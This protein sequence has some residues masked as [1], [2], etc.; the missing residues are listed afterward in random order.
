MFTGVW[1]IAGVGI[2]KVL[3]IGFPY[4]SSR[5]RFVQLVTVSLSFIG[6]AKG[7]SAIAKRKH[8]K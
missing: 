6:L 4:F 7:A 1:A 3:F 2:G 8:D 5:I